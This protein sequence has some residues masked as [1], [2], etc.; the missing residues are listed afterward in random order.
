MAPDRPEYDVPCNG[1]T[2]CCRNGDLVRLLPGDDHGRYRTMPHP[3]FAGHLALEHGADGNC[4]YLGDH[5]CTIHDSKPR[6]C[7]EMDCRRIAAALTWT[8]AR[9]ASGLSIAVWRRG[10]DLAKSNPPP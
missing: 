3:L 4:V 5:G 10:K 8:E 7:R 1:C 6:M 9:K 2:L